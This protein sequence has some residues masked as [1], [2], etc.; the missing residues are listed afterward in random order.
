MVGASY[1]PI[2]PETGAFIAGD[3][4]N[5]RFTE[6]HD[7][8]YVKAVVLSDP[9]NSLALLTYDCIGLLYPALLEV[10]KA[11]ASRIP[12]SE[13]D[14]AHIVMASTH[15]HSG[16]DVVGIWGPDQMTSGVDSSYMEEIVRKSADAIVSAW[17]NRKAAGAV[18][19]EATFGEGWVYNISDSS[20]LDRSLTILQFLDQ[21]GQS[22][23]TLSN[24]ACHP[25]I[26]DATSTAVSADFVSA[27][28]TYLDE[29]LGGANLFL[30]GAVGGWVQPEHEPKNFES[31]NRRGGELGMAIQEALSKPVRLESTSLSFK[32]RV[33]NLPVSNMNFRLLAQ[34]GVI[35]RAITDSVT[36]EVAFFSIGNAQFIT[37]PGETTPTHSFQSKKLMA[38]DGP[39]FVIG[40]GMDAL[41]Y[42]LTPEF[43]EP[44]PPVKHAEYLNS[45]SVDKEAG[46]I[47][48][49]VINALV[50]DDGR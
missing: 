14:P 28:Y 5:R 22:I 2:T 42:I 24:F 35:N 3:R 34:M 48:M 17:E 9:G 19:A 29:N 8:L 45:M 26:M 13:F 38:G 21:E 43:Y 7:P 31:V 30:Q 11:V 20:N 12:A 39:K 46:P 40:L 18:Y 50:S 23:A 10:R 25:T 15:T 37:H 44:G 49:G 27:M 1:L 41:G 16:P 6:V 32:S 4:N 47:L 36:T 33:F